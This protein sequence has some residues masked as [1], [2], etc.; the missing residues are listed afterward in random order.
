MCGCKTRKK[1]GKEEWII[2]H[3]IGIIEILADIAKKNQIELELKADLDLDKIIKDPLG[4]QVLYP[5][6]LVFKDTATLW[7]TIPD[8]IHFENSKQYGTGNINK[9]TLRKAFENL[10][11]ML[12]PIACG[13]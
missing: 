10:I 3:L 5:Y 2:N 8:I 11:T 6:A 4:I 13:F 1:I 9:E 7:E 12:V